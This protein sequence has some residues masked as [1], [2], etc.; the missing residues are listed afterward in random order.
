MKLLVISL[1]SL[2]SIGMLD[3]Q[4]IQV[5]ECSSGGTLLDCVDGD[6]SVAVKGIT[7]SFPYTLLDLVDG[8]EVVTANVTVI[9]GN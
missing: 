3:L 8:I 2:L 7:E 9:T 4:Q 6:V 5:G 1:L